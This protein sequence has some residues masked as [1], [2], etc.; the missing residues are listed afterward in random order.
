MKTFIMSAL[1]LAI[2]IL[3]LPVSSQSNLISG[4]VNLK[5][6]GTAI[7]FSGFGYGEGPGVIDDASG[8]V[9]LFTNGYQLFNSVGISVG[10]V[11]T[12]TCLSACQGGIILPLPGSSNLYY[13]FT[14]EGW[15]G[16]GVGLSYSVW[17]IT[18]NTFSVP[19]TTL[20][21]NCLEQ[22]TSTCDNAGGYWI[23]SH[24]TGVGGGTNNHYVAYHLTSAGLNLT[25]VQ[26][27]GIMEYPTPPAYNRYGTI[28][29]SPDGKQICNA[30][31]GA[32]IVDSTTVEIANFNNITGAITSVK[33][34]QTNISVN[35]NKVLDR[36]YSSAFSSNNKVLYIGSVFSIATP[37][38]IKQ[39][40]ISSGIINT[41]INSR[42]D[43]PNALSPNPPMTLTLAPNNKIYG[44]QGL[45]SST[46]FKITSPN[47]VGTGCNFIAN[48]FPSNFYQT[49]GIFSQVPPTQCNSCDCGNWA[50]N[51]TYVSDDI[52]FNLACNDT[53]TSIL[54]G[55]TISFTSLI[56]NCLG[57]STC[58]GLVNWTLTGPNSASG[59][60]LPSFSLLN[61]GSY[62]L[63]LTG[64]CAGT[65]CNTCIISFEVAEECICETMVPFNITD[66]SGGDIYN[67]DVYCNSVYTGIEPAGYITFNSGGYI[68]IGDSSCTSDLAWNV[69]GPITLSGTG[70][71]SFATGGAGTYLLT[72]LSYCGDNLCDSCVI[73]F[74][75]EEDC[76][77]GDWETFN[78]TDESGGGIDNYDV[79][80]GGT[81]TGIEPF[82]FISF[83]SGG[84]TCI[85]DPAVCGSA[86]T[87]NV[88]G[89]ITA[90]GTGL[91]AFATAAA[92]IYTLTMF[93]Y[94]GGVLCDTCIITFIVEEE[95]NCG[96]W[97]SFIIVQE[98]GGFFSEYYAGCGGVYSGLE[99]STS[100]SFTG[101]GYTCIGDTSC[102]SLLSWNLTGPV[103][104]S[105]TGLPVFNTTIAGSYTLTIYG[106]CGAVICD[107]CVIVFVVEEDVE[108]CLCGT[109][110]NFG[111]VVNVPGDLDYS[112]LVECFTAYP[113]I[114]TGSVI[115]FVSGGYLCIGDAATCSS[116]LSW[117]VTGPIASSGTGYPSF[118][119]TT[120]GNYTLTIYGSCN[121]VDCD[122]CEIIFTVP[123][124]PICEC[125][126]WQTFDI[127]NATN[128]IHNQ[129]CG[130]FYNWKA[131]MPVTLNGTYIC[132]GECATN[133]S[134]IVKRNGIYF[135]SGTGM[136]I[137]FTPV[138]GGNYEVL[139]IPVCGGIKCSPCKF[140]FKVKT[141]VAKT[142]N[143]L[144][145]V[146]LQMLLAPNPANDYVKVDIETV[147]DDE[148]LLIISNELGVIVTNQPVS[149]ME[150]NNSFELNIN[151]LPAGLYTVKFIGSTEGGVEQLIITR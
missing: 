145:S 77:C 93:G 99:P 5:F 76:N 69:S 82:G 26:S 87:W 104:S 79:I 124:E 116:E 88:T 60:G 141:F 120:P 23:L 73:T 147:Y 80:C 131:G 3:T 39:F 142:D 31:G 57:D 75:V 38:A 43:I 48:A 7:T 70:L 143:D 8:N 137:S 146:K 19:R 21:I 46:I 151:S 47:T 65:N 13:I 114:P 94:C 91:P 132:N 25:P 128:T 136:P 20:N 134:W 14:V 22:L 63:S 74:I 37:A 34:L 49:G 138:S 28:I 68:C 92:G 126:Y 86:I 2:T 4:N 44:T 72:I 18:T 144:R 111:A 59:T 150:G 105:G 12:A 123:A 36:A 139:I 108:E 67:Y 148:G 11:G 135:T 56:Y 95:C 51:F 78:I 83:N 10:I 130:S 53:I 106:Y 89:P 30:F 127:S 125:G 1:L 54:P 41:I 97:E 122:T 133:Y 29:V 35:P 17:N 40:D 96:N 101:G 58:T 100:I 117:T 55:S 102:S 33:T 115:S 9:L 24:E 62:T 6:P 107:S 61:A 113:D 27:A 16:N 42:I 140:I 149:L 109:W 118:T 112:M 52:S 98:S 66:E 71:P 50:D 81:Y 129:E 32:P 110:E 15:G 119:L 84:Y 64:S 85:G 45:S 121:G 103:T 90:S